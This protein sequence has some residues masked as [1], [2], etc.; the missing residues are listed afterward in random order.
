MEDLDVMDNVCDLLN[1]KQRTNKVKDWR[2]LGRLFGFTKK[3][4][5]D[6]SPIQDEIICP[7]EA[8]IHHLKGSSPFLTIA[9]LI[10]AVHRID[11]DD[12]LSVLDV[13]IPG[14]YML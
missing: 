6:L 7:T 5:N 12:A 2:Y 9:D 3:R 11:R 4:L 13:Y 14:K 10:W 8:L 1:Q